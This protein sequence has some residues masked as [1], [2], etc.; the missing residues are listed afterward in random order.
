MCFAG[1]PPVAHT[2]KSISVL[3]SACMNVHHSAV[4]QEVIS[5]VSHQAFCSAIASTLFLQQ[6]HGVTVFA[7]LS[8]PAHVR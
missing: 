1:S 5:R 7:L 8:F 6:G 2:P 4:R 3:F